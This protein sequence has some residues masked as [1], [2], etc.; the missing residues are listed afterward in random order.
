MCGAHAV[1]ANGQCL[2]RGRCTF[3]ACTCSSWLPLKFGDCSLI[4]C[5]VTAGI[6]TGII[7]AFVGTPAASAGSESPIYMRAGGFTTCSVDVLF[8]SSRGSSDGVW[9]FC[10]VGMAPLAS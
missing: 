10:C 5:S 8:V 4:A 2:E 1:R 3:S 6:S 9:W 7:P